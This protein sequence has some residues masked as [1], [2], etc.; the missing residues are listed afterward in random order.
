MELHSVWNGYEEIQFNG[1]KIAHSSTETKDSVRWIEIEIYRTQ[2]GRY[3]I[4][5]IGVSLVYHM[6]RAKNGSQCVG[7]GVKTRL[8]DLDVDYVP[9]KDCKPPRLMTNGYQDDQ[10]M[11]V[12]AEHDRHT[13]DVCRHD[14]VH[15]RL[16][17]RPYRGEP[18]LSS[19]A[20]KALDQAVA[21]DPVLAQHTST[22]RFVD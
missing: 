3:V 19:P 8:G 15:D 4:H 11:M 7:K 9:C 1:E 12:F 20:R 22:V 17:V 14:E 5:R 21:A 2:S 13:A 6:G 18:F 16:K 10:N